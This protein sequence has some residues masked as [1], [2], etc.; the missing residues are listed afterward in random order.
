MPKRTHFALAAHYA[1][2][3]VIEIK[4]HLWTHGYSVSVHD[5]VA[6]LHRLGVKR[7]LYHTVKRS[8]PA[9]WNSAVDAFT[10]AAHTQA[11]QTAA[12]IAFQL[13]RKGYGATVAMVVA[14]LEK[15]EVHVD[16]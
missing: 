7:V 8:V 12:Q 6:H 5:V 2:K 14:S 13:C 3:T 1:G 15:Q 9:A 4:S 16:G 10:L 11:G